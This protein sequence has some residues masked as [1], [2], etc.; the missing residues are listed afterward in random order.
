MQMFG[1]ISVWF[2]TLDLFVTQVILRLVKVAAFKGNNVPLKD[3]TTLQLKFR[4]LAGLTPDQVFDPTILAEIQEHIGEALE[5]GE[6]RNRCIHDQ[7]VFNDAEIAAGRISR[8]RLT[9]LEKWNTESETVA[10]NLDDLGHFLNR[11][12][13]LQNKFGAWWKRLP[14]GPLRENVETVWGMPIRGN[15]R[16]GPVSRPCHPPRPQV[17]S[18][19]G[20]P[21]PV[22][23]VPPGVTEQAV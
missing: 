14:D 9:R 13:A 15:P 19:A 18:S 6:F 11:I 23:F 4:L 16:C 10:Y 8:I 21:P 5:V 3:T 22:P 17:S 2:A 1:W 20:R 12:G 7:W